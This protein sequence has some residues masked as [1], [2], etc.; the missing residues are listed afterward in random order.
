MNVESK[1]TSFIAILPGIDGDWRPCP[2]LLTENEL[3]QYLRIP[4]V[5]Q[6]KDFRNTVYNLKR[7]HNLPCIHICGQ[8]LY[9]RE[10]ID[11]W[12]RSRTEK[13]K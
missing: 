2:E 8:P 7:M 6:A 1:N 11:A 5:S 10:A 12:I 13:R 4:E 3:I 9:P